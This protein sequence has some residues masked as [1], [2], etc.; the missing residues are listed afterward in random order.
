MNEDEF[1]EELKKINIV[2]N[3]NQLENLRKFY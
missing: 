2:L 1:I 3:E